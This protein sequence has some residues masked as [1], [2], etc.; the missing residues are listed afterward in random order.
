LLAVVLAITGIHGLVSYGVARRVREIGIRVAIGANPRQI[1]QLVLAKTFMLLGIGA[2]IGLGLA[3]AAGRILETVVFASPRDPVVLASVCVTMIVLGLI[4]S[5]S[6]TRRALRIEPT[7]ALR[8][9]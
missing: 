8:H 1:I 3:L 5:W 2:S 4:S 6:P 9:E 7:I